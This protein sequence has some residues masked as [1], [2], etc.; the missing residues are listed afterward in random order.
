[1]LQIARD[2]QVS[3]L[4]AGLVEELGG[5]PWDLTV[6]QVLHCNTVCHAAA[7][8]AAGA[9]QG[10]LHSTPLGRTILTSRHGNTQLL[11][12]MFITMFRAFS[13]QNNMQVTRTVL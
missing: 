13:H 8:T 2:G 3:E 4:R 7:D 10:G 11:V 1:M 5:S 9:G 12:I 6:L